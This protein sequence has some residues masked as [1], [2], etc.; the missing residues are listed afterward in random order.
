MVKVDVRGC[1]VGIKVGTDTALFNI[2]VGAAI[3]LKKSG[4]VRTV[5]LLKQTVEV[6]VN[7]VEEVERL[8][9]SNRRRIVSVL[10]DN[11]TDDDDISVDV[12]VVCIPLILG[13]IAADEADAIDDGLRVL[14]TKL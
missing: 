9:N 2:A 10:T 4:D 5:L 3:G 11:I 6:L 8:G 12:I 14:V 7:D 1:N 13:G